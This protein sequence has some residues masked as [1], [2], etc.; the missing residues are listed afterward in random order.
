MTA[1][2]VVTDETFEADVLGGPRPVLVECWAE[3]CGP[4]RQVGPVLDA[5]AAEH[6]G[7]LDVV[8]LNVDENPRTAQQYGILAVPT[9]TLFSGGQ[10]VRQVVGAKSKAALL[11]EFA[12]FI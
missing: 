12:E 9:I 3:W 6:A 1:V 8:K 10:L 7:Q 11:R 5:I 2:K 4:C